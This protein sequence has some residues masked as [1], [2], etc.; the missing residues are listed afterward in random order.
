MELVP[1]VDPS[2]AVVGAGDV[3]GAVHTE[4]TAAVR[5]EREETLLL[6]VGERAVGEIVDDEVVAGE[7]EQVVAVL[8]KGGVDA[9]AEGGLD[10]GSHLVEA[11]EWN[12]RSPMTSASSWLIPYPGRRSPLMDWHET[13][14]E[15]GFR[16]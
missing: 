3:G 6:V 7:V 9:V 1:R 10:V 12:V 14:P 16:P 13:R 8:G 15:R 11:V 5:D 4:I 2:L